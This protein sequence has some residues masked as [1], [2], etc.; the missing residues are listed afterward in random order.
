MFSADFDAF[1]LFADSDELKPAPHRDIQKSQT[2]LV[3]QPS[4][5]LYLCH[6]FL[7]IAVAS[8]YVYDMKFVRLQ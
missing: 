4:E 5:D 7:S 1:S 6:L 2:G 3:Q 8:I